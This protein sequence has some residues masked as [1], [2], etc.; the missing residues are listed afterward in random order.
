MQSSL[1]TTRSE[2]IL[3]QIRLDIVRDVFRAGSRITEEGL[4]ERYGVSRTPIREALRALAQESLLR[5]IPRSGYVVESVDLDD[6]DDLYAVR[7]AI[8]EQVAA[9]LVASDARPVMDELHQEWS[10]YALAPRDDVTMVF[11]DE[12]FHE[13]LAQACGSGVL[14]AMLRNINQRLHPLRTRDFTDRGRIEST[15]VQHTSI[16]ATLVEG[17]VPLA[18]AMLRSHILQSYAFV[19]AS[20][21]RAGAGE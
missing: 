7:I 8:E 2:A 21:E 14:P 6:M 12:R 19:R 1:A 13:T 11:A 3:N 10:A 20:A 17:N 5:H 18:Q 15:L 9:R 4:A 16:I